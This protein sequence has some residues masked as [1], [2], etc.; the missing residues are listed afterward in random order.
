[1][2]EVQAPLHVGW[3]AARHLTALVRYGFS[4]PVQTLARYG[5]L[6][7][8]YTLFDYGCGRG[9][10]VRGLTEN[11]LD[12]SGWDPYFAPDND[13]AAADIVNLGFVVNVIEDFDERLEALTRAWSLSERLLVVSVMLANQNDVQGQRF[14]DGVLTK[15]RTFQKYYSQSEIKAFLEAAL[16]E[17]PIPVAPGVLYV[18]RD[19]DAEQRFLVDRYRS[20]R[21]LL[22][23]P[24]VSTWDRPAP[25]RRDRA[26]EKYEAFREPLDRLWERWVSLGRIPDKTEVDDL[27]PL[28]EGFGTL[29]KALRFIEGRSDPEEV[30]HSQDSRIADLEVYFALNQFA[31]RKPYKHLE[32]GLQR[33]IKQFFGDYRAAQAA[34]LALLMQIADADSIEKACRQ[35][36]EHG[37]GWLEKRETELQSVG[38]GGPLSQEEGPREGAKSLQLH[39]SLSSSCRR[40]CGSM[41]AVRPCSTG[42]IGTRIW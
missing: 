24:S 1:M 41:W 5:F 14:R 31:R 33:D 39:V 30:E 38:A 4:A 19:K 16:E 25:T 15:R 2:G 3:D 21:N 9:D 35:A 28:T 32:R 6:D 26:A 12:A 7:G 34:G 22:R 17:E 37:L 40:C 11:G 8:S 42:T 29:G 13:V 23:G 10:D 20:R 18:F 36:A 27:L